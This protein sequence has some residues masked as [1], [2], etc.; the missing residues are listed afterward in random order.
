MHDTLLPLSDVLACTATPCSGWSP[1]GA[2]LE[3]D[4]RM[5][6]PPGTPHAGADHGVPSFPT[7]R[8]EQGAHLS[9]A[10][11]H[12]YEGLPHAQDHPHGPVH[13]LVTPQAGARP[14]GAATVSH[15]GGRA[16]APH[17]EM[18]FLSGRDAASAYRVHGST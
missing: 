4:F 8:K 6:S 5:A 17:T 15:Q 7:Q 12:P 1:A 14:L 3:A 18:P 10:V 13:P 11:G 9:D 16:C 2:Q